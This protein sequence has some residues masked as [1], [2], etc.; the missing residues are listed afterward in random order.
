M[1]KARKNN[2][3]LWLGLHIIGFGL[4]IIPPTICTL[5]YFPIWRSVRYEACIAGGSALLLVICLMPLFKLI[6]HKLSSY[7]S[8]FIWLLL[9]I[10]FLA[11]SRIA[12]QMTVISLV[13]FIGNLLGTVCF[14]IAKNTEE[15]N[16]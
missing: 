5:S 1:N 14:H 11:L 16:K 8:S 2:P 6:R 13:G 15:T 7:G 12:D 9:F 10:L 3:I 4:C